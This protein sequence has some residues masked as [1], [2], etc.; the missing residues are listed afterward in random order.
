ML[1]RSVRCH[2]VVLVSLLKK[3]VPCVIVL[4]AHST[5]CSYWHGFW[6]WTTPR[7]YIVC[8]L[9]VC[10]LF[11]LYFNFQLQCLVYISFCLFFFFYNLVFFCIILTLQWSLSAYQHFSVVYFDLGVIPRWSLALV[12]SSTTVCVWKRWYSGLAL[13]YASLRSRVQ[14]P[15]TLTTYHSL[16]SPPSGQRL[17]KVLPYC[18]QT[19]LTTF[20]VYMRLRL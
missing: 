18:P 12:V 14:I 2:V 3:L 10:L 8:F 4:C 6:S 20:N 13:W 9:F 15:V 17:P 19:G 5:S 7:C 16:I 11:S 1:N